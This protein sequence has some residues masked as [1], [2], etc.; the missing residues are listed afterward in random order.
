MQL[1]SANNETKMKKIYWLHIKNCQ[2]TTSCRGTQQPKFR[3]K[4]F[5][6][7]ETSG[8]VTAKMSSKWRHF[9]FS[10]SLPLLTWF[11]F[12]SRATDSHHKDFLSCCMCLSS[13]KR[14]LCPFF[15]WA[16]GKCHRRYTWPESPSSVANKR[17]WTESAL[18]QVMACRLLPIGLLETTFSEIRIEIVEFSLRKYILNC[19]L[20]KWPPFCPGEKSLDKRYC[21]DPNIRK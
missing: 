21:H 1:V 2:M 3:Q 6:V 7:S 13:L 4:Y 8:W 16:L 12:C 11:T 19:R 5:S 9:H 15:M 20:L 17:Q 14:L 10:E 18:V